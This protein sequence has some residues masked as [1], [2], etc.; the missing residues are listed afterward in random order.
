MSQLAPVMCI[1][2]CYF[3]HECGFFLSISYFWQDDFV[4]N[5]LLLFIYA[6]LNTV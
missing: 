1:V 6:L 5:L 3:L 2:V 4:R